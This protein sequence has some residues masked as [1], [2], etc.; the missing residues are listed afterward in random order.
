MKATIE[1]VRGVYQGRKVDLPKARIDIG[2]DTNNSM[3]F[4]SDTTL[5]RKHAS[6]F[7]KDGFWY[8]VDLG[9]TNGTYLNG[10]QIQSTPVQILDQ[11]ILSC[12]QQEFRI[13]YEKNLLEKFN[14]VGP[15]VTPP[16][17]QH[18]PSQPAPSRGNTSTTQATGGDWIGFGGTLNLHGLIIRNPLVYANCSN[19]NEPSWLRPDLKVAPALRLD[20]LPYWPSYHDMNPGQRWVYLKWLESGRRT[21]VDVGYG[22][23]FFYG[24]ERRLTGPGSHLM[25]KDER[26]ALL[27]ELKALCDL[28]AD[29]YSF[30]SYSQRLV[31][32]QWHLYPEL[33]HFDAF[34]EHHRLN[35]DEEFILG[36]SCLSHNRKPFTVDHAVQWFDAECD[37][38]TKVSAHRCKSEAAQLFRMRVEKFV[39]NGIV[40][41][42]GKS[43]LSISYHPANPSLRNSTGRQGSTIP[44]YLE[45]QKIVNQLRS[46]AA[47][48]FEDLTPSA[49]AIGP[50]PTP[51]MR[52]RA[53]FLLP[54]EIRAQ[55]M[56][57]R[58]LTEFLQGFANTDSPLLL[59]EIQHRLGM[60]Q[61]PL[62]KIERPFFDLCAEL[63]FVVEP[64]PRFGIISGNKVESVVVK[65]AEPTSASQVNTKLSSAL[66]T[67]LLGGFVLRSADSGAP[68][69]GPVLLESIS[70][71]FTLRQSERL[72]LE[73]F[74]M[75]LDGSPQKVTKAT[76]A[77]MDGG[78]YESGR[79]A[80]LTLVRRSAQVTG[81][82]IKNLTTVLTTWGWAENEVYSQLHEDGPVTIATEKNSKGFKVPQPPGVNSQ[83]S[84]PVDMKKVRAQQMETKAVS[85]LLGEVFREADIQVPA[86]TEEVVESSKD[87]IQEVISFLAPGP[88]AISAWQAL[89]ESKGKAPGALLELINDYAIDRIG[90]PLIVGDDPLEVE[91][92]IL[93]E[94]RHE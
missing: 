31:Q 28:F 70:E 22:F 24:L 82:N 84:S 34:S 26:M 43:N 7:Y 15:K 72:R 19:R 56:Q 12:G 83:S 46:F 50:E 14:I 65:V 80:L 57:A 20:P 73:A 11:S 6:I 21:K 1:G 60:G 44:R 54:P 47:D 59:T 52:V 87:L 76:I 18:L 78:F 63:G 94:L 55:S 5:S 67:A 48:C 66:R 37:N 27:N 74:I 68:L 85:E 41:G 64:D 8:C 38:A 89:A 3:V 61:E 36:I 13:S 91:E 2:R 23:V 81:P 90:D 40:L 62:G 93:F 33:V 86:A 58:S 17:I 16:P 75:W 25:P 92:D 32:S 42:P 29:S 77:G 69:P 88:L 51:A 45:A 39:G 10:V 79:R 4:Q 49:K 53:S 30:L 71:A 9:S 35:G